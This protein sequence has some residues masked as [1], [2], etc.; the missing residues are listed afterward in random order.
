MRVTFFTV[1]EQLLWRYKI[2]ILPR[3]VYCYEKIQ[4]NHKA[5]LNQIIEI[6][7]LLFRFLYMK[8][9]I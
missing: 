2:L 4:Q 5:N 3:D 9:N 6:H 7:L 8:P 1:N